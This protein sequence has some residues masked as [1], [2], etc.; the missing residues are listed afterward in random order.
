[1][2]DNAGIDGRSL[3]VLEPSSEGTSIRE[4]NNAEQVALKAGLTAAEVVL[5]VAQRNGGQKMQLEL[6]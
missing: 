6:L 3:V 2:L 4:P 1:M 5:P